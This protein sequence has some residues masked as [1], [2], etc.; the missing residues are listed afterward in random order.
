MRTKTTRTARHNRNYDSGYNKHWKSGTHVLNTTPVPPLHWKTRQLHKYTAAPWPTPT[1]KSHPHSLTSPGSNW[2]PQRSLPR[3]WHDRTARVGKGT[4]HLHRDRHA[5]GSSRCSQRG[6][7]P[8]TD[9]EA[10]E[11]KSTKHRAYQRTTNCGS[12]RGGG[13]TH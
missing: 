4:R 12:V 2:M 6:K 3:N 13:I 1:T 8:P 7:I 10:E 9:T 5:T 11:V